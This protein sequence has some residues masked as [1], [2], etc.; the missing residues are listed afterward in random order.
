MNREH[1]FFISNNETSTFAKDDLAPALPL[2]SLENTLAQYYKSLIP[3][4]TDEQL[5]NSSKLIEDFKN[6][7]GKKLQTILEERAKNNK[8]W[9]SEIF[10]F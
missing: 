7:I 10:F 3:F 5:K 8:N 1:F 4:G 9:V 6:G 2:P